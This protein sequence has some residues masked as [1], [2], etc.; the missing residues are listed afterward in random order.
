VPAAIAAEGGGVWSPEFARLTPALVTEAQALGVEVIPWTVNEMVD[1]V[2]M[3]EWGVDGV[4][5][6]YPDRAFHVF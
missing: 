2:R 1:L 6:D 4:I 3:K 5:T